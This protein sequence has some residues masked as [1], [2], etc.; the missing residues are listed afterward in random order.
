MLV[1]LVKQRER[2]RQLRHSPA[3]GCCITA[4]AMTFHFSAAQWL[5]G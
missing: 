4:L 2:R 3:S 5:M 1:K